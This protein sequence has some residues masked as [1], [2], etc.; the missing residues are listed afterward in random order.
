[1]M[2]RNVSRIY[3]RKLTMIATV[4]ASALALGL[5]APAIAQNEQE[6]E[7][8]K[9]SRL[10][11]IVVTATKR[12]QSLQDTPV[13]VSVVGAEE[14][15]RAEVQD[16]IDLQTLVPSLSVRQGQTSGN[17]SFYIRGFGNGINAIGL[18]PSVGVFIDGVYRSRSAAAISDLPNLERVEVLRGPQSTLFG[19]NASAGLISVTTKAPQFEL[20]G[21]VEASAG[22]YNLRR[23][24]GYITG[25]ITD[26]QAVSLGGNFN[27]RDGYAEDLGTGAD[28]NGRNRW[29]VRGDILFQPSADV[30]FR[31]IADYDKIDEDCC[32]LT[33]LVDGPTGAAVRSLGGQF[34]AEDPFAR[35]VYYNIV[36]T[37]EIE[38]FGVSLQGNVDLGF[39]TI[40]SITAY[41]RNENI[42][43]SDPDALSLNLFQTNSQQAE[44]K[45]F[46]QEIRI[47]SSGDDNF[48]DWTLGGF[49]FDE[50]VDVANQIYFG[51]D[52]RPFL[53]ALIGNPTA[54]PQTEAFARIPVGTLG[55]S[56]QGVSDTSRQNNTSWSVFATVDVN[57]TDR[58]TATVGVSYLE[59]KKD[60]TFS[61]TSTDS[62][63]ALNLD[64]LGYTAALGTILQGRGINITN[65]A[66]VGPFVQANPMAYAQIQQQALA[67]A[68]SD[69]NR[70]NSLRALQFWPPILDFPNAVEDGKT[71]DSSTD[72]LARLSYK[73]TDDISVY[74][75]YA[76]GF[77]AS[78]WNL[79]RQRKPFPTDF[80]GGNLV[81]DPVTQRPVLTVP[82]SA[83]TT[84]GLN[85]VNL[86]PGTRY[87][88]PEDAEVYE[89][90]IKARFDTVGFNITVFKQTIKNFQT[91]IFTEDGFVFANAAQ[92]STSGLEMDL[93]WSPTPGLLLTGAATF[94]DPVYDSFPN[95][96]QGLDVSGQRPQGIA[97]TQFTLGANYNF[98]IGSLDGF[99]RADWQYV[100]DSPFFDDPS[101][102]AI[103]RQTDLS[104]ELNVV[105]MSV[106]VSTQ[107]EIDVT[108][109][110]RNLFDDQYIVAATPALAQSGSFNGFPSQPRTF[111]VTL[112][113]GF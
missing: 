76:T 71:R 24:E 11:E 104:R 99:V 2:T 10:P 89:L 46:T 74:A 110:A 43:Q 94:L 31:L 49:Y 57:L 79:S 41:R 65:P 45:T 69:A 78:S 68:L 93:T 32:A 17:T 83:I 8:E 113:K 72:F 66:S 48:I 95:F 105:N 25:P 58:L 101:Q 29:A 28:Y 62:L 16:L 5:S 47:Q 26:T 1:M 34:V 40:T 42:S 36:P 67:I 80:V 12:E 102:E 39:G 70:F 59:D 56:G 111:G 54:L 90:G 51:D 14:L 84:A 61:A 64:Q 100:G 13:A 60:V 112:R 33:N 86:V 55:A 97:D 91:N 82:P 108:I 15:E 19:K 75:S 35:Q 77:K 7:Q 98:T 23:V 109:W 85:N 4:A 73:V 38:N 30:S 81:V 106:G 92:Q 53:S 18:E 3:R 44:F 103:I 6:Q 52:F 20:D 27:K 96:G 50:K 88:E 63:A 22:N 21:F 37:N 87:A 9:S 107:S